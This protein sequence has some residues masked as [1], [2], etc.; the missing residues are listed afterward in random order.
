MRRLLVFI[1]TSLIVRFFV[2]VPLRFLILRLFGAYVGSLLLNVVGSLL[3]L[4]LLERFFVLFQEDDGRG[5]IGV[6]IPEWIEAPATLCF[7]RLTRPLRKQLF[8]LKHGY[9]PD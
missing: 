2:W 7:W 5:L 3:V 4:Y 6:F 9:R 1:T 8:I